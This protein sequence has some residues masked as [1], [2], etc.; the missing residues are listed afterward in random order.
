M[1]WNISRQTLF[2]PNRPSRATLLDKR[3]WLLQ[4]GGVITA[5]HIVSLGDNL[6]VK[7]CTIVTVE[8]ALTAR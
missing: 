4:S 3:D 6:F 1:E 5:S 7:V 2:E 8:D